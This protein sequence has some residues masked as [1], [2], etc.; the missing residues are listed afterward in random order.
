[1]NSWQFHGFMWYTGISLIKGAFFCR[2]HGS[3]CLPHPEPTQTGPDPDCRNG[4]VY[5]GLWWLY[6]TRMDAL[7]I[8]FQ[9]SGW[10]KNVITTSLRQHWNHGKPFFRVVN[11]YN[12]PRC[13]YLNGK[14]ICKLSCLLTNGYSSLVALVRGVARCCKCFWVLSWISQSRVTLFQEPPP[15]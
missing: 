7:P 12:L 14:I 8:N 3:M 4:W 13:V 15:E 1:M 6:D 10:E 5:G 9:W 11:H 2:L